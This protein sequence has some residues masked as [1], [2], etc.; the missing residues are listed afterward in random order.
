MVFGEGYTMDPAE[1]APVQALKEWMPSTVGDLRKMLGFLSYYCSY[2]PNFSCIT[3]PLYQLLTAKENGSSGSEMV[4][5][6][7]KPTQ[8]RKEGNLA[9]WT[10]TVWKQTHQA[11]FSNLIDH[12]AKPPILG[13]PDYTQSFVLH[14]NASQEGLGAV[15]YQRQNGKMVVIAYGPRT[16][17]TPEKN[18]H[19]HSGK[20]EFLAVKW[21][22]CERFHHYLYY[23]PSFVVCTDNN[24]LTLH[25][26]PTTKLTATG[27]RWIAL[28][29]D[30]NFYIKYRSDKCNADA[31]GL[32]RTPLDID[33]FMEQCTEQMQPEVLQAEWWWSVKIS[34][35]AQGCFT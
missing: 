2:I 22:V 23:A 4:V 6:E 16:L 9:S 28:L 20:L 29:A 34:H 26:L 18:Y 10:H 32:P 24:P 11:T 33:R 7:E 30:F 19:M 25:P 27:H 12:L 35:K 21:T 15:L 8:K 31:D 14:C 3:Q 1:I 13:F 17:S 5:I